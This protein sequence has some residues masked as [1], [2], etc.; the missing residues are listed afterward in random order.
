MCIRWGP[1]GV[2]PPCPPNPPHPDTPTLWSSTLTRSLCDWFKSM[3]INS[4]IVTKVHSGQAYVHQ[5]PE[6]RHVPTWLW[7]CSS[8]QLPFLLPLFNHGGYQVWDNRQYMAWSPPPLP[9][10]NSWDPCN[11][12]SGKSTRGIF[13]STIFCL[14][15]QFLTQGSW[16]PC[17]FLGDRSVF[18]S[19][20]A[21]LHGLLDDGWS[22]E[23]PSHD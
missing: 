8:I 9:A 13:C 16:N 17:N 22:L 15:P 14:W 20:E 23:R 21:T 1:C 2:N 18:C 6:A 12:L 7:E 10:Q 5:I 19:N 11:L 4:N 3:S